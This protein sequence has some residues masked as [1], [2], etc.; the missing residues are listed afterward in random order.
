METNLD[1]QLTTQV[2][3]SS[4]RPKIREQKIRGIRYLYE[5][6]PFWDKNKKQM[7]HNRFYIGHYI[8]DE[9]FKFSKNYL[10]RQ[11]TIVKDSN[12]T[13]YDVKLYTNKYIGSTY[14]FNQIANKTGIYEDLK[15]IFPNIYLQILSLAYYMIVEDSSPL[16]LFNYYE[17]KHILPY[18]HSLPSQRISELLSVIDENSK[19]KFFINQIKRRIDNEY[20]AYDI[21]SISSYS[22]N[23]ESVK[24]GHN[25]DGDDLGQINLAIIVG[26]KSLLPV[27]YRILPGNINDVT[28]INKFILDTK[29]LNITDLKFVMD[30][31]FYSNNNIIQL[32][33]NDYKFVIGIKTNIKMISTQ[34][35]T[36]IDTIKMQKNYCLEHDVYCTTKMKYINFL[37]NNNGKSKFRLFIHL[38]FDALKAEKE[39]QNFQKLIGKAIQNI[40]NKSFTA[41]DKK[42][43]SKYYS[44]DYKNDDVFIL[45][46]DNELI[47]K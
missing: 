10:K 3:S 35:E 44:L 20:F 12:L 14:L 6:Y 5:D 42:L 36:I 11:Q 30:R 38:Y 25:K 41:A 1:S 13:D 46:I 37:N 47:D 9:E 17:K 27:Y 4:S 39:R 15:N 7:R 28:T 29:F 2:L 26:E 8:S 16:Y 32:H 34:I 31:G 40:K 33:Q 19:T 43:I 24:Y 18:Q 23:I 21:T 45:S 22:E